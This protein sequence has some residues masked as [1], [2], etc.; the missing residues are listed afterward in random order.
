[1]QPPFLIPVESQA[2]PQKRRTHC[3]LTLR[4]CG[5]TPASAIEWQFEMQIGDSAETPVSFEIYKSKSLKESL[6]PFPIGHDQPGYAVAVLTPEEYL[7]V[8]QR[9]AI[10]A[11][12]KTLWLCGAVRYHDVFEQQK[13]YGWLKRSAETHQTLVCLRYIT[14][15]GNNYGRWV[16]GGPSGYNRAT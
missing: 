16:L 7:S 13:R 12:T 14:F 3:E 15:P 4:N 1:M 9:D 10:N 11:G 6:T 2:S 5:N 8:S